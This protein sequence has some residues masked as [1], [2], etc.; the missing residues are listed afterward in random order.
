MTTA[1]PFLVDAP[2]QRTTPWRVVVDGKRSGGM[3]LGE[4]V[5]PPRTAGPSRHMHTREDEGVYIIEGMLTAEVGE[6]RF[7]V[8]AGAFLWM[9]R[10][11]P[12]TF[13]N[14]GDEPVRALGLINPSGFEHFFAEVSA[15]VAS[16]DGQP[17]P[18][19]IL[20]LNER[21]G[22]YPAEGAPLI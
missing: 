22:V 3:S 13:A 1:R 10:G 15:Y 14:L 2:A 7:E 8:A 21:Y 6:Q 9:P 11:L 4:G 18:D 19:V 5:L 20:R 16:T 17:D 12:H